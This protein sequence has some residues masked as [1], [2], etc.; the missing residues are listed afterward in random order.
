MTQFLTEF[1]E[2]AEAGGEADPDVLVTALKVLINPML[3]KVLV[4]CADED[5]EASSEALEVVTDEFVNELV[6]DV[7]EPSDGDNT[8]LYN[9]SLLIQLLQLSTLLIRHVPK[10]LVNHRK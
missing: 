2:Q 6:D 7:L 1:R 3:E 10:T 4:G 8:T 5:G 9:E